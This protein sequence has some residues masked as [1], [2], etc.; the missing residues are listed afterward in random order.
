MPF[1]WMLGPTQDLQA[2][3]LTDPQHI[4]ELLLINVFGLR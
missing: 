2:F 3:I 4:P 1:A